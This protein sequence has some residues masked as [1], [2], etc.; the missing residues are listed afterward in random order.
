MEKNSPIIERV[1]TETRLHRTRPREQVLLFFSKHR[2]PVTIAAAHQALKKT[3]I[4]LASVYRSVNVFCQK[5]VLTAVD[6]V[7][8]GKR[9]EL[10]DHFRAHHHH[11]ICQTCGKIEDFE[12]CFARLVERKIQKAKKFT[13]KNH[14]FRFFGLCGACQ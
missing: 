14:D 13:V 4:D 8:K 3:G 10:S 5:G 9:Y 1:F 6:S 2:L 7:P 11:L 12:D